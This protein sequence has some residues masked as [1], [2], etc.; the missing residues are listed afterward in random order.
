MTEK[1]DHF[2][3]AITQNNILRNKTEFGSDCFAQ[4]NSAAIRIEVRVFRRAAHRL[5]C[6]WRRAKRILVGGQLNDCVWVDAEF[7]C[8]FLDRLARLVNSEIAQ[9]GIREL[10]N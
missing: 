6:F 1:F 7:A 9:L 3:R 8:R 4:V 2:V 5:N 10:P